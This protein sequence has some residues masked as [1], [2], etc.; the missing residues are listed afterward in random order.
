MTALWRLMISKEEIKEHLG[1]S[2]DF[3]DMLMMR[4]YF[5]VKKGAEPNVRML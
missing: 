2:P 3:A 4:M 1:R 5:E